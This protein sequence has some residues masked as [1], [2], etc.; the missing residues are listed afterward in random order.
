ME[1]SFV[2]FRLYP[3]LSNRASRLIKSP[4]I[5]LSDSGLA[6]YLAGVKKMD[7]HEPLRGALLEGYVAQNLLAILAAHQP[8]ARM[9][10][11]NVQGR[12]EVDFI[13]EFGRETVAVEV[14]HG[15]RIQESD[16]AGI[17]AYMAGS[18][19]CKAGIVAYNGTQVV[20][21]GEKIWG[22]PVSLLLS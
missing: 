10:Y 7:A 16:M 17:K 9:T 6:A 15:S 20:K 11:W 18:K 21:V 4:K 3:H 13:I 19:N 12:F 1:A 8:D 22:V 14:K 5:Y 2:V